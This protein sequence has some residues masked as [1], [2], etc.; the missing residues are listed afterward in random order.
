MSV[1]GRHDSIKHA[2][3]ATAKAL[4]AT[5]N[6]NRYEARDQRVFNSSSPRLTQTKG[7]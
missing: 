5:Q 1:Y 2:R 6:G 3:H 7:M 4:D